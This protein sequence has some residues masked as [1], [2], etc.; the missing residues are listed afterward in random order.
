[1]TTTVKEILGE[2]HEYT[3]AD[4]ALI[5]KAYEFAQKTHGEDKRYSGE[6]YFIHPAAVAK[7]LAQLG[8]DAQTVV[9]GL[10]HDTIEDAHVSE[11]E[12]EK[13]FGP[14]VRKT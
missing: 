14:E 12:I 11:E 8:M 3:P 1:M 7:H 10:L 5:V 4:E 9:A 6:P 13:E 2:M